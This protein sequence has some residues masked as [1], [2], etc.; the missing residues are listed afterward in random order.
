MPPTTRVHTRLLLLCSW[1]LVTTNTSCSDEVSDAAPRSAG[2]AIAEDAAPSESSEALYDPH[3]VVDVKITMSPA[4]WERI[5]GEGRSLTS[6]YA[7]CGKDYEYTWATATVTVDGVTRENVAV[8]KKGF[9]GS[10]SQTKPGLK[11]DF[12]RNVKGQAMWGVKGMTLNNDR[13]DASHT[14]QCMAYQLFSAAK[15][16][17]PRCNSRR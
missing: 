1:I 13:Q 9:L 17:A 11:I 7:G 16:P 6:V 10:L 15:S 3:R 2:G 5:L 8:R 14:H 12:N 4:E